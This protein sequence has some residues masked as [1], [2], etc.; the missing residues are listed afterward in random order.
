M[1]VADL[2]TDRRPGSRLLVLLGACR[3]GT[4]EVPDE[5]NRTV[6]DFLQEIDWTDSRQV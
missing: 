5:L 6:I 4:M 2:P 1:I 3:M